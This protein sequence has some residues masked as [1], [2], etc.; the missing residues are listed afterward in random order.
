MNWFQKRKKA[1]DER[2][3]NMQNKIYREIYLLIMGICFLSIV[4]KMYI[5]N[6]EPEQSI[7]EFIILLISGIYYTV[8]ATRLG[9]FSDEVEIHDRNCKIPMSS[10]NVYFGL[11]FGLLMSLF[12][13]VRSAIVYGDGYG[14]TIFTFV[15]VFFVSLMMYVPF[16]LIVIVGPFSA[17]KFASKKVAAKDL[18][19]DEE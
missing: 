17:A 3:L 19:D 13:G 8:R 2:V 5:F 16:F 9:I 14:N 18:E 1:V 6:L 4:V 12:F 11:G 7:T 10:K 15:L